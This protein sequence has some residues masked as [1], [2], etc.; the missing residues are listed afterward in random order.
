[1]EHTG[2]GLCE[3]MTWEYQGRVGEPTEVALAIRHAQSWAAEVSPPPPPAPLWSQRGWMRRGALDRIP[4]G[5][6]QFSK[7]SFVWHMATNKAPSSR[8]SKLLGETRND[9]WV[10]DGF[11]SVGKSIGFH[12]SA[13]IP[14]TEHVHTCNYVELLTRESHPGSTC[15][16]LTQL[17]EMEPTVGEVNQRAAGSV[18]EA[19]RSYPPRILTQRR[20]RSSRTTRVCD[21]P[22]L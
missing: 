1:M 13:A 3:G 17:H 2:S 5:L 18:Q 20:M 19:A 6:A 15:V 8:D 10:P 12:R 22:P 7:T 14:R 9:T 21:E 11:T 4:V 16:K